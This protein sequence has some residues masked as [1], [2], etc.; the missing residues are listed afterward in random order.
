MV[1]GSILAH[2]ISLV[3]VEATHNST[4][5]L[6]IFVPRIFPY[7]LSYGSLRFSNSSS[8]FYSFILLFSNFCPIFSS[9]SLILSIFAILTNFFLTVP[10]ILYQTVR[11]ANSKAGI[12]PTAPLSAFDKENSIEF[13]LD[14]LHYLYNYYIVCAL[15]S[16]A[17]HVTNHVT[18]LWHHVMWRLWLLVM[19]PWLCDYVTWHFPTL[20]SV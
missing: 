15:F 13:P 3:I 20:P 4:F 7:N 5:L 9:F 18:S 11:V 6:R 17:Y 2:V 1:T 10:N 8:L 16:N 14:F 19:W 12:K